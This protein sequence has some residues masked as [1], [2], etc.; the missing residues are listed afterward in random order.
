MGPTGTGPAQ[1]RWLRD[2]QGEPNMADPAAKKDKKQQDKELDEALKESFPGSD[3]VSMTQ[4]A[5]SKPDADSK[6]KS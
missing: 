1:A 5:P 2:A 4:P 3:P 6:H